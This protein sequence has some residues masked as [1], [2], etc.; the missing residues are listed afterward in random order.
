[1]FFISLTQAFLLQQYF[2]KMLHLGGKIRTNLMD[3]IYKKVNQ[4]FILILDYF[5][6]ARKKTTVGQMINLISVDAQ[7]FNE[8]PNY[9]QMAWTNI[10]NILICFVILA[11]LLNPISSLAG[12]IA[13]LIF[14][15]LNSY[16]TSKSKLMQ[17]ERLKFQ[18]SRIKYINEILNGI[19]VLNFSLFKSH[20]FI[21][22]IFF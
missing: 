10:L 17:S 8:F 14:L 4:N 2:E 19:K 11:K 15:P 9:V 7:S 21:K 5:N 22:Y 16:L 3:L 1:M 20:S 13:I 6:N 18:D 12:F